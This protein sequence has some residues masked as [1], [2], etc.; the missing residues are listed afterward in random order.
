MKNAEDLKATVIRSEK[1]AD[2]IILDHIGFGMVAGAIPVPVLDIVAVS[3]IQ[4]DMLR[5]LAKKYMLDFDDDLGKSIV[6]TL[7]G[8]T[9]G[10]TIGRT[11]ASAVKAIPGIGTVLGI[12]SQ[13]A[14][15]G[16]TTFAIGHLFDEHFR[17]H[18][19]LEAFNLDSVR[20]FFEE[21][22]RKGKEFV[23]GFQKKAE[24]DTETAKEQT[25]IILRNMADKGVVKRD[26]C[27]RIIQAMKGRSC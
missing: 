21:L 3:A 12:G 7:L 20:D 11:G 8:S 6:S 4:L 14:L 24:K 10:T 9:I 26:D 19:P 18:N 15:S 25:A 22:L 23:D 1:D 5:Q 17:N 27:E 13:V 2:R 16:I